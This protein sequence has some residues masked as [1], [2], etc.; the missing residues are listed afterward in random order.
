M[1]RSK[2]IHRLQ[3]LSLVAVLIVLLIT[4]C[5]GEGPVET[6]QEEYQVQLP[7]VGVVQEEEPEEAET[8]EKG[9]EPIVETPVEAYPASEESQAASQATL[10]AYPASEEPQVTPKATLEAYPAAESTE[11]VA[12][13]QDAYPAP[14]EAP[15]STPKVEYEATDPATVNLASGQLQ[16]VEFFAFW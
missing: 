5:S 6:P 16:L 11:P 10:D 7:A 2:L 9:S 13:A 14:E 15:K 8:P 4:A 1:K 12:T 3:S